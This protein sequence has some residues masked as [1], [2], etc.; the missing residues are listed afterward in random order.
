MIVPATLLAGP[1]T[2]LPIACAAV[3][4]VIIAT[5]LLSLRLRDASVID[6]VWGPAFVSSPSSRRSPARARRRAVGCCWR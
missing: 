2:V 3:A 6:P 4:A 1:G 5:W